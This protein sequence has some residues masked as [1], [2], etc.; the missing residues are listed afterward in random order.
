ML[1]LGACR[2]TAE[3]PLTQGKLAG[4]VRDEGGQSV[5]AVQLRLFSEG[6]ERSTQTG[7]SGAYLFEQI[8]SGSYS[9]A[10]KHPFYAEQ[11]FPVQIQAQ[12]VQT[13]DLLLLAESGTLKL[14]ESF[15]RLPVFAGQEELGLEASG[16]WVAS[17]DSP[18][19]RVLSPSGSGNAPLRMQFDTN[20][21]H[22]PRHATILISSGA[23]Q[24]TLELEQ[25]A[26]T[27]VEV[28]ELDYGDEAQE[29]RRGS[30]CSSAQQWRWSRSARYTPGASRTLSPGHPQKTSVPS[31]IRMAAR[32]SGAAMPSWWSMWTPMAIATKKMWRRAFM[33][34]C[35]PS[36]G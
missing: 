25:P 20:T 22:E 17:T 31:T 7:S 27:R 9:L 23:T 21:E 18:W 29:R 5:E 16:A 3:D 1:L 35:C 34:R 14:E 6:F 26:P 15:L 33:R 4:I 11:T 24:V 2:E 8:P 12:V 13:L 32:A 30:G 10:I 19:L 36:R 28:G